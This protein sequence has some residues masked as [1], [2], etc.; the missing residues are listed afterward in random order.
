[1]AK[2]V[3]RLLCFVL[4]LG[5]HTLSYSQRYA[6]TY[7]FIDHKPA[8]ALKENFNS[9]Q[10]AFG[11][12]EKLPALLMSQGYVASS[13]D[14]VHKGKDTAVVYVFSGERYKWHRIAFDTAFMQA[15]GVLPKME[16][17]WYN[18][19]QLQNLFM[20]ALAYYENN[21][22]PFAKISLEN[23][24]LDNGNVTA[25]VKLDKGVRYL[26]DSIK[27]HGNIKVATSF[28]EKYLQLY[29]SSSYNQS[30]LNSI[31]EKLN[32][33][34]FLETA[35]PSTLTMLNS[36]ATVNLYLKSKPVNQINAIIGF[37]PENRQTGG[38]LLFTGEALLDLTNAF[39]GAEN[40]FVQWQQIQPKSP[41][42]RLGFA[43]PYFLQSKFGIDFSFELFK[44]DSSFLNL[45]ARLGAVYNVDADQTVK[46]FLQ[47]F[48][49]RLLE[50][51]TNTI[52][53]TK[54]LPD[55][56]DIS[57]I[58]LG[59][60]YSLNK[61]DYRNNPR[62]GWDIFIQTL[63]GNKSIKQNSTITQLKG[64][65]YAGLYDSVKLKGYQLRIKA[66]INKFFPV[67]RQSAVKT[68]VHAGWFQTNNYFRNELFQIGG[69]KLLR[70]FDEESI[71]ASQ[72]LVSTVEYR[73]L[74]QRN[75]FFHVFSDWAYTNYQTTA[76]STFKEY[77]VSAGMGI[78]MQMKG[79]LVNLAYAV[80]KRSG[81]TFNMRQSKIHVGFVAVF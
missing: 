33:L 14:S 24:I 55:I 51:D 71:Y 29:K 54:Q 41:R 37:L 27:I 16:G 28:L 74:L 57:N 11:Y 23:V 36:G 3:Y 68:A 77:Y 6:T 1:M 20:D 45:A 67:G 61:T 25:D 40:I 35:Q 79:S 19:Q 32:K 69:Y 76:Y 75:A 8:F 62:R 7:Y 34:S 22:H 56:L 15:V 38:K 42:L 2:I 64:F 60:D 48:S 59:I 72:Y 31:D 81:E 53:A 18:D 10:E 43:Q 5:V 78:S 39:A 52:K 13:I 65:S 12:I 30:L 49:T 73:Y 17:N 4:M 80:G 63:A 66:A 46:V 47:T 70:G 26:I 44:K 21:G 50:V 58:N 9:A